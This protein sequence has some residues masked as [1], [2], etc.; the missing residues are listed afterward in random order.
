MEKPG[1]I[2]I[3]KTFKR[4]LDNLTSFVESINEKI[5]SVK[6]KCDERAA[7]LSLEVHHVHT[8]VSYVE[9]LVAALERKQTNP[10]ATQAFGAWRNEM[11]TCQKAITCFKD[12]LERLK[13]EKKFPADKVLSMWR[14]EDRAVLAQ[15]SQLREEVGALKKTLTERGEKIDVLERERAKMKRAVA[16]MKAAINW[17]KK[18]GSRGPWMGA[19]YSMCN[20]NDRTIIALPS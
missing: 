7:S 4:T 13:I 9:E 12:D 18:G 1:K 19:M 6:E 16:D 17:Q 3:V 2:D 8:R 10:A 14:N 15:V 20:P 11:V 5:A